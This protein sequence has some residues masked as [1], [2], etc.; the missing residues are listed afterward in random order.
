MPTSQSDESLTDHSRFRSLIQ[1]HLPFG[2]LQYDES[3][4]S[5]AA[6]ELSRSGTDFND[7]P[8]EDKIDPDMSC[9]GPDQ[10]VCGTLALY[11][12]ERMRTY[13]NPRMLTFRVR[14]AKRSTRDSSGQT[15]CG[16]QRTSANSGHVLSSTHRLLVTAQ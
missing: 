14:V 4:A 15:C 6:T 3:R 12:C 5:N 13:S 1:Q 10:N 2:P 11:G 16:A 8:P 9:I 7:T